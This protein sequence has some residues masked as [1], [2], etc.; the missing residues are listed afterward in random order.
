[1]S[2]NSG[3]GYARYRLVLGQILAPDRAV[4]GG[5]TVDWS[6]A[7]SFIQ[8]EPKITAAIIFLN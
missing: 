7:L 1:M 6:H 2:Q 5:N 8:V 3:A 4:Q